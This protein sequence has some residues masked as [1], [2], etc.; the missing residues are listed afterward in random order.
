MSTSPAGAAHE[1]ARRTPPPRRSCPRARPGAICCASTMRCIG[2]SSARRQPAPCRCTSVRCAARFARTMEDDGRRY[3]GA[4]RRRSPVC[5]QH[6]A[7]PRQR[8]A[9][10]HPATV[11]R[12]IGEHSR[13]ELDWQYGY[14]KGAQG[15]RREI[16]G[17]GGGAALCRGPFRAERARFVA[18]RLTPWGWFAVFPPAAR[19]STRRRQSPRIIFFFFLVRRATYCPSAGRRWWRTTKGVYAPGSMIFNPPG[20]S[21]RITVDARGAVPPRLCL[22]RPT[23]G[24]GQAEDGVLAVRGRCR[25]PR[26]RLPVPAPEGFKALRGCPVIAQAGA[27]GRGGDDMTNDDDADARRHRGEDGQAARRCRMRKWRGR[28]SRRGFSSSIP[29]PAR[30]SRRRPSG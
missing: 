26:I 18:S 14:D 8:P 9:A 12:A 15:A 29:A 30:A 5:V 20:R 10:R 6:E 22:D 11:I 28:R 13:G 17:G 21:H 4:R 1:A 25:A 16:G 19:A 27:P 23:R 24:A 3:G 2:R 7:R